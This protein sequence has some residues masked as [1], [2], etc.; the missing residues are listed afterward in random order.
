[1][2]EAYRK[3]YEVIQEELRELEVLKIQNEIIKERA[4]RVQEIFEAKTT[5]ITKLTEVI[6]ENDFAELTARNRRIGRAPNVL[7]PRILAFLRANGNSSVNQIFE[8]ASLAKHGMDS[9]MKLYP[10][11][12]SMLEDQLIAKVAGKY[13]AG[14][15]A[16][17]DNEDD[18]GDKPDERP[19][20]PNEPEERG[21]EPA[22]S[23]K[24]RGRTRKNLPE[25]AS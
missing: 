11:L 2:S 14:P 25:T 23:T 13:V 7:Q 5:L 6:P 21:S 17:T 10:V 16:N 19:L 20:A 1:M 8:G 4:E 24:R 18:D 12:R 9:T 15:I 22:A 3:I